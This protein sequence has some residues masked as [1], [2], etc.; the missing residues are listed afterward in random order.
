MAT[1]LSACLP[2]IGPGET[3]PSASQ[4]TP[5]P[6]VPHP[7]QTVPPSPTATPGTD[8]PSYPPSDAVPSGFAAAPSGTGL[9]GYLRQKP[10]W[11]KCTRGECA[12]VLAPLDYDNPG[13]QALTLS[14]KRIK[15]SKSP[16][17]GTL[18][19]NPGGPGASGVEYV[20]AFN[21][22]GLERFDIVGWDPRGVGGSTPVKCYGSKQA[23]KLNALDGSPDTP[24][25]R[26]KLIDAY[27]D[28][29]KSCW[30]KSGVLLEHIS[31]EDT[32]KD[33][34]LLRQLVGDKKLSYLGYSY[35]TAIGAGY[36]E[37][38]GKNIRSL[39]LD[40]A[41]SISDSGEI[42]QAQ[43]FDTALE[44]FAEWCA[45]LRCS[46]GTSTKAVI[47]KLGTW[48]DKLDKKPVKVG[49]RKLTQTLAAL[50]IGSF[51]YYGIDGWPT[52]L[53]AVTE[54]MA[55]RAEWLLQA[56]DSL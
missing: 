22:K 32:V 1:A 35:G 7:S 16:R 34:D 2:W 18:F 29:G 27:R 42:I 21:R 33:L 9:S 55:G 39:V 19:V 47:G 23:D 6:S 24:A 51:L 52:L 13:A 44:H 54:A 48:L 17:I 38:F 28:F 12:T 26:Q 53:H 10:N 8:R 46:L 50:G 15:A 11:K 37:L 25:E 31:T 49:S 45:D 5:A 3:A 56:G 14:L 20:T 43:G 36:A 4:T 41:V 40:A 30:E